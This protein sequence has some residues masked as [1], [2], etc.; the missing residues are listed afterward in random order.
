MYNDR[1]GCIK[2]FHAIESI[3]CEH[4]KTDAQRWQ[5]HHHATY[6]LYV[7]VLALSKTCPGALVSFLSRVLLSEFPLH[8]RAARASVRPSAASR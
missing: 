3:C 5:G 8:C 1:L 7:R 4:S 6:G 2:S